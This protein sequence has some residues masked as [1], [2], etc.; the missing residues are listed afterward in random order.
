MHIENFSEFPDFLAAAIILLLMWMVI[1]GVKESTRFNSLFTCINIMVVLYV[2]ICGSFKANPHNWNL[3]PDEIP[4]DPNHY[5]GVGGF[6]PYGFSGVMAGAATCFY[7]FVGF[8]VIATSAEEAINPSRTIPLSII[9]SLSVVFLAYLGV[10]AIVTLLHPYYDLRNDAPL[11]YVFDKVGWPVAK[12]VVTIGGLTGLSTSLLGAVF[13][14]PRVLFA[15]GRDGLIFSFLSHVHPKYKTPIYATLS[16]GFLAAI[17]TMIFDVKQLA[18]MMSIGTLMAYSL[19]ALS[20]VLLRFR[21]DAD[22]DEGSKSFR[23]TNTQ[24]DSCLSEALSNNFKA[25][26]WNLDNT[27]IPNRITSKL[28]SVLAFISCKLCKLFTRNDSS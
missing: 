1:F 27:K 12:W 21:D 25:Y 24:S 10:S 7:A 18:D 16:G 20:V 14:L 26:I 8:D 23:S 13:P 9:L 2:V 15:M 28:S 11:P 3:S 17:L 19:A 5:N 4:N 22:D 6:M